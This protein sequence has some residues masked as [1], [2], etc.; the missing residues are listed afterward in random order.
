MSKPAMRIIKTAILLLLACL[1]FYVL[2][3][4]KAD[5]MLLLLNT[6]IIL[7][8]IPLLITFCFAW[9]Y[10]LP[11]IGWLQK[12]RLILAPLSTILLL[13]GTYYASTSWLNHQLEQRTYTS[14]YNDCYEI[15]ATRGLVL[16]HAVN[17][18]NAGNTVPAI[19]RAFDA[20]AKGV[21]FDVFYDHEMQRYVVSHNHP[22]KKHGGKLLFLEPL[23]NGVSG[24]NHYWWIDIKSLRHLSDADIKAAVARLQAIVE[25]T[26]T[27]KERIYVEGAAPFHLGLFR[28]AGFNTIFDI[29]PL[30]DQHFMAPFVLNL[31]KAIY[32]FGNYT[33]MGLDYKTEDGVVYGPRTQDIL[34]NIPL[35]IYHIPDEVAL[36]QKLSALPQVRVLLDHDHGAN[37]YRLT[38]CE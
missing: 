5:A 35:F 21:E 4:I 22:Y 1:I 10:T 28:D 3:Q 24:T 19:Q 27:N 2:V 23:W 11:D 9:L 16:N 33:V 6:L 36:L 13:L 7:V 15:W 17:D 31:Y 20:G 32:Y 26:G 29:Q 30:E 37:H 8:L 34:G 18:S 12:S 38:V 25:A 14:V